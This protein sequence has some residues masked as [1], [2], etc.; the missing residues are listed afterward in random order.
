MKLLSRNSHASFSPQ[1]VLSLDMEDLPPPALFESIHNIL[2][3][4]RD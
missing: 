4:I 3:Q 1:G 2:D